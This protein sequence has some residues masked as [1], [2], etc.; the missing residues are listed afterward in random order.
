[1]PPYEIPY[2]NVVLSDPTLEDMKKMVVDDHI[3]PPVDANWKNDEVS[4]DRKT[5]ILPL[6]S[7]A[8]IKQKL[9]D[10]DS[11]RVKPP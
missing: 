7:C 11:D 4:Y 1:M 3:R 5:F 9:F 10:H 2:H 8:V 6:S